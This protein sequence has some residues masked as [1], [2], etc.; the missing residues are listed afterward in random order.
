MAKRLISAEIEPRANQ[1]HQAALALQRLGFRVL[2]VGPTISVQGPPSLWKSTFH[3]SFE[4]A[5][6]TVVAESGTEVTYQRAVADTLHIPPSLNHLVGQVMFVE[7][8]EYY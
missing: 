4:P 6:K 3:V 7:P 1:A 2:H 8:P 5:K